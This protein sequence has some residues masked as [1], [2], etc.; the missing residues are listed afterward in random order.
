[1]DL[2]PSELS[3]EER[4]RLARKG[5]TLYE[6]NCG[7]GG[8]GA[9]EESFAVHHLRAGGLEVVH[10]LLRFLDGRLD[11][12]RMDD[13]DGLLPATEALA[14]RIRRHLEDRSFD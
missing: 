11:A 10:D 9:C 12:L 8:R 6:K 13:P 5:E 3:P 1:M 7:T 2:A 14:S 4:A